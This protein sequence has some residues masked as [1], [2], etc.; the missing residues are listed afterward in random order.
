MIGDDRCLVHSFVQNREIDLKL[1]ST[2]GEINEKGDIQRFLWHSVILFFLH[3]IF[4]FNWTLIV[5]AKSSVYHEQACYMQ[6]NSHFLHP[7][8]CKVQF[9]AN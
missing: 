6:V 8:L 4:P 9:M 3:Q 2:T 7:T 1:N 5:Y